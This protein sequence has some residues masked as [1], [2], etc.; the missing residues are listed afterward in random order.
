[1]AVNVSALLKKTAMST[2]TNTWNTLPTFPLNVQARQ[3]KG[4]LVELQNLVVKM[5]SGS[6]QIMQIKRNNNPKFQII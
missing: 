4:N 1:M 3:K 5:G 2:V 6:V